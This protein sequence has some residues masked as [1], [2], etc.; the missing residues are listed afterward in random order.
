M[1]EGIYKQ[2]YNSKEW[3]KIRVSVLERDMYICQECGAT[4]C[5]TVHHIKHIN[6]HNIDN[7]AITLNPDNLETICHDCHD[8]IHQR[9][10]YKGTKANER[11]F[12]Y[13]NDGNIVECIEPK[14]KQD[15]PFTINTNK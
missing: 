15:T 3:K 9:G 6:E 14:R 2:F 8:R 5:N 7:P 10:K 1:S 13:D 11:T 4:D 12:L